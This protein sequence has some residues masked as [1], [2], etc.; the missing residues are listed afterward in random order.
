MFKKKLGYESGYKTGAFDENKFKGDEN[1][2]QV[3]L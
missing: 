1:F 2:L 3:Y